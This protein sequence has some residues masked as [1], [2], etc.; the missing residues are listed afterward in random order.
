MFVSKRK[1][2]KVILAAIN[3][4]REVKL[5]E[6]ST[7]DDR[8]DAF[9]YSCGEL[10]MAVHILKELNIS[11]RSLKGVTNGESNSKRNKLR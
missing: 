2:R 8:R 7:E 9:M 3:A 11:G 5:P 1:I 10:N 6:G 4:Q